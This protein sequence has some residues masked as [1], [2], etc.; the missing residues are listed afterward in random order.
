MRILSDIWIFNSSRSQRVDKWERAGETVTER[1]S[2]VGG[3]QA[4]VT[5]QS[6]Q[7]LKGPC[8]VIPLRSSG[9]QC[10]EVAGGC[11]QGAWRRGLLARPLVGT[12]MW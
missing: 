5:A 12:G 3:V 9:R 10:W 8:P 7:G 6:G 1:G 2:G 4:P 11:P